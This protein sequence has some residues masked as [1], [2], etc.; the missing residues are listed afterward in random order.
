MKSL[1]MK[2]GEKN[3]HLK[4]KWNSVLKN[5]HAGGVCVFFHQ[6]ERERKI[7]SPQILYGHFHMKSLISRNVVTHIEINVT[8]FK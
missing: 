4:K 8:Y 5:H 1:D 7:G 3:K 2:P 6:E